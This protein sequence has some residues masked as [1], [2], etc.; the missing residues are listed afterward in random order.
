MVKFFRVPVLLIWLTVLW[1]ALWGDVTAGNVLGG[2]LVAIVVVSVARPTGVTGLERSYF[3]PISA[4][5]YLV[6]FLWQ[7]VKSSV[8]VAR[9]IVTPGL[10]I[11][12]AI[13]AVPMCTASAGLVTLVANSIT[14]TPGTVTIDVGEAGVSIGDPRTV[15]DMGAR[16]TL[17]VHVLHFEDVESVRRDVLK[18]ERLAIKAFGSREELPLIE[19]ELAALSDSRSGDG[20]AV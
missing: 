9:E 15:G 5:V 18:L 12:R 20:G 4:G 2:L 8:I 10:Q 6:Y 16:R 19:A 14:L 1:V 11:N 7:L 13:I 3:R 17:F